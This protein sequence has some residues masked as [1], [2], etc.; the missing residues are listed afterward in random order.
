MLHHPADL[1]QPSCSE[2]WKPCLCKPG[3]CVQA[4]SAADTA[5][6]LCILIQRPDVLWEEV[7]P[8]FLACAQQGTLLE[9]L[10]PHILASKLP[11]FPPEIMQ[12]RVCNTCL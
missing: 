9:Q 8:R 12:V 2:L 4:A 5:V 6:E 11:S 1:N 10:L 3:A 7:Y